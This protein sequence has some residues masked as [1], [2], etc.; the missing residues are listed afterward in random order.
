[1][2]EEPT[3]QESRGIGGSEGR[4]IGPVCTFITGD[5]TA[6]VSERRDRE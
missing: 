6:D 4:N 1:M 3:Q 5:I 2:Y